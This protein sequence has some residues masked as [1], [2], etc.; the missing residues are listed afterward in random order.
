MTVSIQT[1]KVKS[2]FLASNLA[3]LR[4]NKNLTQI[5]MANYL[6]IT[7]SAY[8][9]YEKETNIPPSPKLF[10]LADYFG[11]SVDLLWNADLTNSKDSLDAY[12]SN[13]SDAVFIKFIDIKAQAGIKVNFYNKEYREGLDR[14]TVPKLTMGRPKDLLAFEVSGNSMLPKIN[15]GDVVVC[16]K[17]PSELDLLNFIGKIFVFYSEEEE[18]LIKRLHEYVADSNTCVF[19]SDNSRDYPEEIRI[20]LGEINELWRVTQIITSEV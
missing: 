12:Y 2:P 19:L 11:I 15:H 14:I 20:P 3:F 1:N 9:A 16:Q 18:L 4:K 8:I 13:D 10:Q 7:R 17:C 5:F 6:G